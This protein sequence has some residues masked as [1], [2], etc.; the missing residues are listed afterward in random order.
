[1]S[2]FNSLLNATTSTNCVSLLQTATAP[3]LTFSKN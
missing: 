2:S 1:M 3:P